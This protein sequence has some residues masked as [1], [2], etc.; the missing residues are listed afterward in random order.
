MISQSKKSLIVG[1]EHVEFQIFTF[2]DTVSESIAIFGRRQDRQKFGFGGP[3]LFFG[4]HGTSAKF[5]PCQVES[6]NC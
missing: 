3:V 1:I 5:E 4:G 2:L 6:P